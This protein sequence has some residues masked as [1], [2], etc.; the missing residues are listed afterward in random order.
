MISH[1]RQ[2]GILGSTVA[3]GHGVI[4]QRTMVRPIQEL[5]LRR[6]IRRLAAG[7]LQFSTFNWFV[8]GLALL[9]AAYSFGREARL[10]TGLL[11]GSSYLF[12]ALGNLWATRARHLGWA[13][14][15]AVL[16]LIAYGLGESRY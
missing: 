1:S 3:V 4:T 11:A 5:G 16:L 15:G 8:S 14:S 6:T 9:I 2:A 13:L 7:L 10:A 12:G